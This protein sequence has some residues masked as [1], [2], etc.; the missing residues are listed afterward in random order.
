MSNQ[1]SIE[2][3]L[4]DTFGYRRV[5]EILNHEKPKDVTMKAHLNG[6][7]LGTFGRRNSTANN[8]VGPKWSRKYIWVPHIFN[9][10]EIDEQAERGKR[11]LKGE[12][13]EPE[14]RRRGH[15]LSNYTAF[16]G[17]KGT[18]VRESIKRIHQDEFPDAEYDFG[19]NGRLEGHIKDDDLFLY[20]EGAT[21]RFGAKLILVSFNLPAE[22]VDNL[23]A[24]AARHTAIMNAV[25][26]K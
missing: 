17:L 18:Q 7:I 2:N 16:V 23:N 19:F 1:E 20:T 12:K 10:S 21:S 25:Y 13:V 9:A 26:K 15:F 8:F 5:E 22:S 24:I 6:T 14:I 4:Y 3:F 11:Y